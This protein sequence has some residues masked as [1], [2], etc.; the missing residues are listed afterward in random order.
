V[1][2]IPGLDSR[3]DVITWSSDGGSV[4]VTS[5][6]TAKTA[7]IYKVSI[8][9]GKMDLWRTVGAGAGSNSQYVLL[10]RVTPDGR[11]YAYAYGY[12]TSEAY[13]VTG[14]K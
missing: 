2:P 5:T 3:Y 13:V 6:Q 1:R 10:P 9:T 8:A 7:D 14:L 11:A 12:E 4:Y